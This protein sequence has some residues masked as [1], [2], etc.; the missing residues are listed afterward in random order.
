VQRNGGADLCNVPRK[1]TAADLLGPYA[2]IVDPSLFYLTQPRH[3][4]GEGGIV[5]AHEL[6]H[7]LLLAHGDGL[8]NDA[9]GSLPPVDGTR[10]FDDDCD[11][12][13]YSRIDAAP[14]NLGSLMSA[15]NVALTSITALQKELARTAAALAPGALGP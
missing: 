3:G 9:N 12:S 1:L 2:V 7:L 6:G 10:R 11:H 15:E 4:T 13:E 14:G 8:D 5:L